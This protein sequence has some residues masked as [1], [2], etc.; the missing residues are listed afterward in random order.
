VLLDPYGGPHFQRV[1]AALNAYL[2]PAW[3]AEQGFA[4]VVADGRGTPGRGLA[5]DRAVHLDLAGPPLEDQVDALHVA[6]AAHPEMDLSRVAIRGWSFGGYLSAL[7]VLRRPDVFHAAVAGA[8]VADFGLYDTFYTERYLGRPQE[9]PDVYERHSLIEEASRLERPLMLVHGFADPA[10]YVTGGALPREQEA[11]ARAGYVVLSPDLRGLG[12]SDPAPDGPPD[13]DMGSTDDV[14]N[15]VRA[16]AT[17]GLPTLDGTRLGLLGHSLGGLLVLDVLA[18]KPGLVKAAAAFA[19]S[20]TDLFANMQRYLAPEDP[21][22]QSIVAAHGTPGT[23]PGYWADVSPR[24]FV[25]RVTEP[26]LI[27]QGDIDQDVPIEGTRE[28]VAVW[29]KAGKA[30]KFVTLKGEDHVFEA[31]WGEAMAAV[32]AFFAAH[33]R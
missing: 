31:R 15:A 1:V 7:A 22:Y 6:A 30:V 26:L 24:T 32:T 11:L 13:L 25:D 16:L 3:W 4:V 20:G 17:S 18:A 27:V 21:I 23:K 28:T 10:D 29:Q 9:H 19:P 5:W 8:P 12:T 33:L 2:E 14:I